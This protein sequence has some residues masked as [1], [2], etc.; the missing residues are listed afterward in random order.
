MKLEFDSSLQYQQDAINAVLNVLEG[1]SSAPSDFEISTATASGGTVN[2]LGIGNAVSLSDAQLLNNIRKVQ[3]VNGIKKIDALQGNEKKSTQLSIEMETGTGKTY[4][5]LRTIFELSKRYSMKKFIIVVP[6]VAIREGV[7]KSIEMTKDHFR[8]LYGNESFNYFVYNSRKLGRVHQF[9]NSNNI[10]IMVINI[11]SFQKD[12][13]NQE[14]V[15]LSEEALK[16]INVINRENDKMSGRKPIEFIQATNPIVIIDEPQSVDNTPKAKSAISKLNSSITLRY[17]ATHRETYNLIYKLDPIQ[18]YDMRLVKRIEVASV[19]SDDSLNDAYVKLVTTDNKKGIRARVEFYKNQSSKVVPTKLWVKQGDDLYVKSGERESYRDGYIVQNINCMPG[20]EYIEFSNGKDL[21]LGGALGGMG[22]EIMRAQV[23]ETVEQHLEKERS[24]KEGSI[25]VLS[26]FFIDKVANYRTYNDDGT[27]SLGKIGRWFEE[28]WNDLTAKPRNRKF[29]T[30]NIAEIHNGYFSRD[31]KSRH[32]KDTSGKTSNDEDTY[33]LIMRDK[34]RLLDPSEPLRFIFSHSALREG[35]DNPNVFQICTLNESQSL[36]K[37]RQEIGRGLRL[38][39]NKQG[40]RVHDDTINRLT[41]IANESYEEFAKSLQK[42]FETDY[43][44]TF[45]HIEKTTMVGIIRTVSDGTEVA[46]GQ[47]ESERIW[48]AL[49]IAGYIDDAGKIL[50]KFDP[51]HT[52]F[53]LQ[54][55]EYYNDIKAEIIDKMQHFIFKNRV[56]NKRKRHEL[57]FQ[58]HVHLSEDFRQ[59]WEKIKQRTRY[60]VTFDTNKLINQAVKR[61]KDQPPIPRV[62]IKATRREVEIGQA[63]VQMDNTLGTKSIETE[64]I[65]VLPDLLAYLQKE[66][67]L[68]RHTLWMILQKSNRLDEFKTNPQRFMSLIAHEISRALHNLIIEGIQYEKVADHYWEMNRI[69]KEAGNGIVRYLNNL[70]QVQNQ[71]KCLFDKIEFESEVEKQFAKDMDSNEQVRL[72]IKLPDWFKVDTPIGPYNPDWA[73]VTEHDEKL[74]FVRE[75][76]STL[77][78]DKRRKE[79]N[80]KIECGKSHFKTIGVNYDVVTKLSEVDF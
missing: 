69:K 2:E 34:E 5:Y 40:K 73:F 54:I 72:F 8:T 67:E 37:K 4:V 44:I 26:L 28:A 61:I 27:T 14:I 43:G 65:R 66:T 58:K 49:K 32:N 62:Y 16:K 21:D 11:Q 38:P 47:D 74:Y 75:T 50:D 20:S 36:E 68:T 76:K 71:Q 7:L 19:L 70:Y 17:S 23:R 9:A 79:E 52:G 30:K 51:E 35:W 59:L 55:D 15:N 1:Q 25:K 41:I 63:G 39:I 13:V 80:N 64:G 24:L 29:A 42:E 56:V 48:E 57:K 12:V 31:K 33:R 3:E 53:T 10:Q 46:I 45:G 18:A 6:N 22:D 60:R 77:D 78:S